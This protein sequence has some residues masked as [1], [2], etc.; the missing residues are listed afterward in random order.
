M[1]RKRV[2]P[3]PQILLDAEPLT[4]A[5]MQK[6][7]Q[8]VTVL[9]QKLSQELGLDSDVLPSKHRLSDSSGDMLRMI[10]VLSDDMKRVP[11]TSGA[12]TD[13]G[14]ITLLYNN[15]GGLQILEP[16]S[17]KWKYVT[18]VPGCCIV[19]LGDAMVKFTNGLFKSSVHRVGCPPGA[20]ANYTRYSVVYFSRPA[21]HIKL[22][23]I[24][25]SQIVGPPPADEVALTSE[26][27]IKNRVKY[28]M[29]AIFVCLPFKIAL[30]EWVL[31]QEQLQAGTRNRRESA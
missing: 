15:L 4:K 10:K 7:H 6:A 5:Y 23:T 17:S 30:T 22:T 12:H 24:E 27:W 3:L 1:D 14:S 18:P 28:G 9:L 2:H 8:I 31:G 20:Q 25:G 13:F 26:E 19:N 11:L 21:D 16:K 29:A